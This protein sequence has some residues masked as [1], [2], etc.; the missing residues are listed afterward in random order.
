MSIGRIFRRLWYGPPLVRSVEEMAAGK[1]VVEG[2]AA[3]A[4]ETLISPLTATPCVAYKYKAVY[5]TPS[6]TQGV[7]ERLLKEAEVYAPVFE[8][9][10]EDGK[11]KVVPET[12]GEFDRS[13]HQQLQA[14]GLRGFKVD[15]ILIRPGQRIRAVGTIGRE[16]ED[17]FVLR[18]KKIEL[19]DEEP[20]GPAER[21]ERLKQKKKKQKKKRKKG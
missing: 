5:L 10:L 17:G 19:V 9:K 12:P 15:E 2:V 7:A 14:G 21:R 11:V 1:A 8:L 4:G 13:E 16:G 6:R 3:A 18:L 20:P